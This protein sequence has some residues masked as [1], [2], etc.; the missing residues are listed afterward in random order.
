MLFYFFLADNLRRKRN[1]GKSLGRFHGCM[2]QKEENVFGPVILRNKEGNALATNQ[3]VDIEQRSLSNKVVTSR[4]FSSVL[5]QYQ[6]ACYST[7]ALAGTEAGIDLVGKGK[8]PNMSWFSSEIGKQTVQQEETSVQNLVGDL[9]PPKI[10]YEAFHTSKSIGNFAKKL[11][12][13]MFSKVERHNRNCRGWVPSKVQHKEQL[14]PV[15]LEVVKQ[16]TFTFYRVENPDYIWNREC[17][18]AIDSA[19]R[20]EKSVKEQE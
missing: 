5:Q 8:L 14:D 10:I 12:F 16:L 13:A 2:K 20:K 3:L 4:Q 19:L 11:V 1:S 7:N 6:A 9:I 18:K 17:V 15:K